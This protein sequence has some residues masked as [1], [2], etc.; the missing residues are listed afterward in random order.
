MLLKGKGGE[1][2]KK[3]IWHKNTYG[4]ALNSLTHLL[5]KFFFLAY[6]IFNAPSVKH[7]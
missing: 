3:Y 4:N 6:S 7:I 5:Q 1:G 2:T